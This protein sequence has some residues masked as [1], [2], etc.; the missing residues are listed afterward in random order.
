LWLCGDDDDVDDDDDDDDDGDDDADADDDDHDDD[1]D[2]DDDDDA[3]VDDAAAMT[4]YFIYFDGKYSIAK[5]AKHAAT[6]LWWGITVIEFNPM[7]WLFTRCTTW[8]VRVHL[9]QPSHHSCLWHEQHSSFAAAAPHHWRRVK[10]DRAHEQT[11]NLRCAKYPRTHASV[12]DPA[13]KVP[14]EKRSPPLLFL[15]LLAATP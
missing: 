5:A 11:L 15:I 14:N 12:F 10:L 2:D 13:S 7:P 3:D 8:P 4:T 6:A 1:D 9:A